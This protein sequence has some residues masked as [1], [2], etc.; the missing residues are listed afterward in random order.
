MS[1]SVAIEKKLQK[2]VNEEQQCNVK[3]GNA[4]SSFLLLENSQFIENVTFFKVH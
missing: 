2:L 4:L 3:L 1:R